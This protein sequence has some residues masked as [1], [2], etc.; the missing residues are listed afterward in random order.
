LLLT[1]HAPCGRYE[2]HIG[3]FA[4]TH[5]GGETWVEHYSRGTPWQEEVRPYLLHGDTWILPDRGSLYRTDDAGASWTLAAEL[6]AGGHSAGALYRSAN[7]A[8][9]IGTSAGVVR[10]VDD[11][12]S[13]TLL[14]NSGHYVFGLVGDGTT[15][16][17][18]HQYGMS[19]APENDGTAWA[20]MDSPVTNIVEGCALDLDRVHGLLYASCHGGNFPDGTNAL[21]RV[22]I[23]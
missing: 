11:G 3:C 17:A 2:D 20:P 19:S 13:W 5:D 8:Y 16:Y 9:Y 15:I 4:E 7:G 23:H 21:W 10:S 1:W 22:R 14:E 12:R 6:G 18:S